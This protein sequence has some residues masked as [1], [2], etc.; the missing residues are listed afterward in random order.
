MNTV[1]EVG[2]AAGGREEAGLM[3][4]EL[5]GA[6]DHFVATSVA[7]P[8]LAALRAVAGAAQV[9]YD[10]ADCVWHGDGYGTATVDVVT[11]NILA[12]ALDAYDEV[13]N[14]RTD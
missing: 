10:V 11:W 9:V 5:G 7:H 1:H 13:R 2:G 8:E 6:F 14:G 4:K 12:A 3:G